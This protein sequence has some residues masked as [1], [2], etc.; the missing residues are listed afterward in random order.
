MS[1]TR[2]HIEDWLSEIERRGTNDATELL[3]HFWQ[4]GPNDSEAVAPLL[5][6]LRN[7]A[8]T[9]RSFAAHWLGA[10]GNGSGEVATALS[11]ALLSDD[12]HLRECAS[13]AIGRVGYLDDTIRARLAS[14]LESERDLARMYAAFSLLQL[15]PNEPEPLE[16]LRGARA[17]STVWVRNYAG[18]ALASLHATV[19][20]AID[21]AICFL[22]DDYDPTVEDIAR[23]LVNAPPDAVVPRLLRVVREGEPRAKAGALHCLKERGLNAYAY[24][25]AI[26]DTLV[27][28]CLPTDACEADLT[29]SRLAANVAQSVGLDAPVIVERLRV[30]LT[31]RDD[32]LAEQAAKALLS[33]SGLADDVR[34][35]AD[36][37]L[38]RIWPDAS[39]RRRV[40][41]G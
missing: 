39:P 23:R 6:T 2:E 3:S 41:P 32:W 17:S 34:C 4:L 28:T 25:Q 14:L 31:S 15:A 26:I 19:P 27:S 20:S 11:D 1:A 10:V 21:D 38:R 9:L 35:E 40:G 13:V 18:G 8:S 24:R 5:A 37:T 16:V 36:D 22:D 30:L 7:E 33:F 29:L 12:E